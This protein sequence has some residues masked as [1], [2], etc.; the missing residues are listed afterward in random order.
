MVQLLADG[1][2]V[3]ESHGSRVLVVAMPGQ[4]QGLT[5]GCSCLLKSGDLWPHRVEDLSR[6]DGN[7]RSD[8]PEARDGGYPSALQSFKRR[9]TV[10]VRR[11]GLV[12]LESRSS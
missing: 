9:H 4:G 3:T 7:P 10:T 5:L 11:G 8:S 12:F 6:L 2:T 1:T